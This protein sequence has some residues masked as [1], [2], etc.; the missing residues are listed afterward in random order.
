MMDAAD[1]AA[2]DM[3]E[4]AFLLELLEG[5]SEQRDFASL[6][7]LTAILADAAQEWVKA[8]NHAQHVQRHGSREDADD[9]LTAIDRLSEL[10]HEADDAERAVTVAALGTARDFRELHLLTE[11]GSGLEQAADSLKRASLLLRDHVLA[12]VLAN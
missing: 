11:I 6:A 4:V 9:F 3:E 10:E 8:V 7:R 5:I 12:D 2:D 1:D